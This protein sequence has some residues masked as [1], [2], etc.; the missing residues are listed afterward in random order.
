[1]TARK[2][3]QL[4]FLRDKVENTTY[5]FINSSF[6]A[7]DIID[8]T[9][10]LSQTTLV[11]EL[12]ISH[13]NLPVENFIPVATLLATNQTIKRFL[14]SMKNKNESIILSLSQAFAVNKTLTF[15]SLENLGL[16]GTSLH[17]LLQ[18]LTTNPNLKK[19]D[20]T[21]NDIDDTCLTEVLIPWLRNN[22]T[23]EELNISRN[24][25][26]PLGALALATMLKEN[27]TLNKLVLNHNDIGDTG[28]I[29]LF[30]AL[31][32]NTR[33]ISLFLVR[34]NVTHSSAKAAYTMLTRNKWLQSLSLQ[35]NNFDEDDV[36]TI[37]NA[38]KCNTTL[39]NLFLNGA[40][41]GEKEQEIL[42]LVKNSKTLLEFGISLH[43]GRHDELKL[44]LVERKNNF[45]NAYYSPFVHGPLPGN[46]S[47][48]ANA[49]FL[50]NKK[51]VTPLPTELLYNIILDNILSNYTY[52]ELCQ[53]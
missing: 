20:L 29:A 44:I 45:E 51:F 6:T 39:R 21:I 9:H 34:T 42:E 27:T 13:F 30:Q 19:L 32:I 3:S 16:N 26:G 1:M 33:L 53:L 17:L 24:K 7:Q 15:I 48:F 43:S 5:S 28:A 22:T 12:D 14:L 38:L 31:E 50:C 36:L 2:E 47:R 11:V 41:I 46:A 10:V 4:E 23:L 35:Q 25:I 37:C 52:K 49:I 18:A 8:L 40:P